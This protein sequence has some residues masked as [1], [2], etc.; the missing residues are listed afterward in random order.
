MRLCLWDR[1]S[2]DAEEIYKFFYRRIGR[3]EK[4]LLVLAELLL[5]P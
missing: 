1:S 4:D 2:R 3:N 5:I